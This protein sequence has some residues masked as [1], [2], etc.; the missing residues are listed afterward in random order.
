MRWSIV[1]GALVVGACAGAQTIPSNWVGVGAGYN[2][3]GSPKVTAWTSLA[4][5]VNEGSQ[6]YSYSTYDV[7]PQR[8]AVPVTSLRTGVATVLRRFG[9]SLY[10]LGFAT[11]GAATSSTATTGSVSGGGILL[12]QFKP[13]WTVEGG[14]RAVNGS[15]TGKVFEVGFGRTF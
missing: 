7:I 15:A 2:P 11:V 3:T 5:V 8:G 13:G 14:V 6:L 4:I 1:V 9:P 12:Y 10:L